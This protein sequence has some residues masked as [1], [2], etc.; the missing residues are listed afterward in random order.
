MSTNKQ[1]TNC[2]GAT[3]HDTVHC[4]L[5]VVNYGALDPVQRLE[6]ARTGKHSEQAEGAQGE[7]FEAAAQNLRIEGMGFDFS[8]LSNGAY[9]NNETRMLNEGW[10]LAR[11]ALAQPSP[12]ATYKCPVCKDS[13][14]MG[15]SDLCL[16]CDGDWDA[17]NAQPSPAPELERPR[18]KV[19]SAAMPE[20]NGK[21]NFTAILMREGGDICDGF[22]I[23]RSKYPDRVRYEADC[24]RWLIGEL[25]EKPFILDYDANKHSGYKA[26]VA[27]AGQVPEKPTEAM[28]RA[29]M[30]AMAEAHRNGS[31]SFYAYAGVCWDAMI[32]A[33]S[34]QGGHDA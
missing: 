14:I 11:A 9:I 23:A 16:A 10:K 3:D 24:V 5:R 17:R 15:H 19:W 6:L 20:S 33:A 13:G 7:R 4:P 32:A 22:T 21:S 30:S 31:Q 12:A 26:P 29:G 28:L 25:P 34:T 1:C 8:K 18:L 2:P 27:Q